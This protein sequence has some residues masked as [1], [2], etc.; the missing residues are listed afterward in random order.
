MTEISQRKADH[1]HLALQAEHQA[2]TSAGFDRIRFE[3]NAMPE[4]HVDEVDCST[5]F[6]NQY[7]SAPLI[8]GAMTGGC[9][10]GEAINRHL[11]EAAEHCQIPMALGSQRA[12]LQDGLPQD[13]RRWAPEA[14]LL[15]N[16]GATQLQQHGVELAQRAVDSVQ[17]NAM[18]IHLNPLQELVQPQGDRDWRGV[19]DAIEACC[20]TLS[21][22]VIIKEVG[23]G[24]GPS[25]AQRLIDVGVNFIEVAGRGGTSWA[26]I[27]NARIE[28][29]REQ[30]IAAPFLD[31]GMNT[32]ELIPREC[33]V[34]PASSA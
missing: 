30:Q 13:V 18:I 8:I 10:H 7:C 17:A 23:S 14:M 27:E 5:V 15:G 33:A 21:V 11:A 22:P 1:I 12:A 16:I 34:N 25:S 28:Q 29:T 6:L 32:A 31:W 9:E 2:A 26:S 20:A 4:L 3:H 19:L 24:I